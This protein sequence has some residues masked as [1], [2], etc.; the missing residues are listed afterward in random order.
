MYSRS[1]LKASFSTVAATAPAGSAFDPGNRTGTAAVPAGPGL[2]DVGKPDHVVG[3]GTAASCTSAAV[4]AAVTAGGRSPS[5]AN[6]L[7]T[8]TTFYLNNDRTT[9]IDI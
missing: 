5:T 1:P 8:T 9:S 2:A 3:T 7:T 4:V 6:Q